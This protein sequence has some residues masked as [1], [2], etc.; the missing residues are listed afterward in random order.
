MWD[1]LQSALDTLE[2]LD[3]LGTEFP[4]PSLTPRAQHLKH[5]ALLHQLVIE[6]SR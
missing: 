3:L 4:C 5:E 2:D 6:T 1:S